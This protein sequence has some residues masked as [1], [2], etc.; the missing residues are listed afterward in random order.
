MTLVQFQALM[1]PLMTSACQTERQ[2]HFLPSEEIRCLL[3][4]LGLINLLIG[5]DFLLW[6][7]MLHMS[8]LVREFYMGRS[9]TSIYFLS[10]MCQDLSCG[11]VISIFPT[12][13]QGYGSQCS[14]LQVRLNN[15]LIA[16]SQP[17]GELGVSTAES[18]L[19]FSRALLTLYFNLIQLPSSQH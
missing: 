1:Q 7:E 2:S 15:L 17:M 3:W 16:H 8:R 12:T 6:L 11:L 9:E 10:N 14:F 13:L 18:Q 5:K 4:S 19:V